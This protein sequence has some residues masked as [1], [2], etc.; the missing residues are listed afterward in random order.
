MRLFSFLILFLLLFSCKNTPNHSTSPT[1]PFEEKEDYTATYGESIDFYKKID[2][3]YGQA[4]LLEVGSTDVG[5]PLHALVL[6]ADKK[7]TPAANQAAD[8]PVL[9]INNG[10]HAGEPCGVDAS[11]LLVRDYLTKDSLNDLLSQITLVIIPFYNVGGGLNRGSHSRANQN[12]PQAYGFRGN[13]KNLDLN[14]DFIKCDSKNAAAFNRLFAAW[15][16]DVFIDNHTTN[17][18][19]Y[20][21]T[22]TM[23]ATQHNKLHPTL[24]KFQQETML[25]D[26][27]ERMSKSPWEMT[28]YVYAQTTPDEGI[29]GFLDLPRYS[30]GYA[31]LFHCYSFISEAH[32]FKPFKDRVL[33]THTF[34][35]ASI[36]FIVEHKKEIRATRK[37]AI[38]ASIKQD[39][40]D[41]NWA[42]ADSKIDSLNFKGYRAKKKPSDIHGKERLYYDHDDHFE[43]AIP[44]YNSYQATASAKRPTAYIVPQAY[45]EIIERL[46]WNGVNMEQ[47]KED[48]T[49]EVETYYIK[50]YKSRQRPYEGHFLHSEVQLESKVQS[51]LFRKGDYIIYT[52]Q[53]VNRYI[54]ETLEPQ[55][56]DSFF[57]WNFFDGILQQKEY[58]SSYVFED[59]ALEILKQNPKLKTQLELK[60]KEDSAF[61][62]N[63]YAQLTFIYKN[64]PHYEPTHNRYPVVR[65]DGE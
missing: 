31:A 55:G 26:L 40:F 16:P 43:Q 52:N 49:L 62:E 61:A 30:S 44:F 35:D 3:Q 60:K 7:F 22:I 42:I 45:T 53:A 15:Q 28:P 20:P 12:G 5:K 56:A 39:S 18:A 38:E 50:D 36:H 24:A 17:G 10:I 2:Q 57:A 14:R 47:I 63:G 33:A 21:Y 8:R 29:A 41:L 11:M 65:W 27:Y 1:I 64:S 6:S 23:I 19:D 4:K 46:Q 58:F 54:I 37:A 34:M 9:F 51:I 32:M 48:K 59:R 13:A 25:P